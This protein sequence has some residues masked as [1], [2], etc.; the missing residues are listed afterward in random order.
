MTKEHLEGQPSSAGPG[1]LPPLPEGAGT[2][3]LTKAR[4][5]VRRIQIGI[6]SGLY[7]PG[8]RLPMRSEI[9][10]TA[11]ASWVT[12]QRAFDRLKANGEVRSVKGQGTFVTQRPPSLFRYGV[13]FPARP[14]EKPSLYIEAFEA[15]ARDLTRRGPVEFR[16]YRHAYHYLTGEPAGKAFD[17]LREEAAELSLGGL[18]FARHPSPIGE[19]PLYADS[20]LPR[21]A[22]SSRPPGFPQVGG[23]ELGGT[24]DIVER[25][26]DYLLER[27]RAKVGA[28]V[29]GARFLSEDRDHLLE[30]AEARK[31]EIRRYWIQSPHV[32]EP[33]WT[34]NSV[35]L[36]MRLPERDRPDGLLIL[37]DH[38]VC[39]AGE[40]LEAADIDVPE[41][42]EV[43][44]HC[45]FPRITCPER[46]FVRLG[47][48][49]HEALAEG[50][51]WLRRRVRCGPLAGRVPL[52]ASFQHE[53]RDVSDI[54]E[55]LRINPSSAG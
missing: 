34:S 20:A 10:R 18:I 37:D 14:P 47:Y 4:S 8:S 50:V 3:D 49:L 24:E 27:G 28:I 1:P 21:F 45:N 25:G 23:M 38:L 43:V 33:E 17:Q 26:L 2:A 31:M 5:I 41:E 11:D 15:A 13:V 6:V 40:G 16:L 19:N 46:P 54:T 51:R 29:P 53:L 12:I 36:L 39:P 55:S 52:P 9:E 22:I 42:V 44:A 32:E 35:E 48:D 7:P 30:A